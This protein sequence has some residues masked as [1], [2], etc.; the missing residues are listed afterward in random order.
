VFFC[1]AHREYVPLAHELL[2]TRPG[3]AIVDACNLI[4]RPREAKYCGI[5][6]GT[7]PAPAELVDT[8]Q[9]GFRAMERGVANE[10]SDLVAFLNASYADGPFNR[11]DF[12]EV[13]RIAG[14]CVTG[15]D[16]VEPGVVLAPVSFNGFR[17]RLVEQAGSD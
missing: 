11:I 9:E 2:A 12:R 7:R 16:I 14:T 8:V 10:V 15:C 1:T 5:G 4:P 6:R 13:Q 17:S 3:L